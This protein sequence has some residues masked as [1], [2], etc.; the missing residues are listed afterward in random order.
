MFSAAPGL[1]IILASASP[2]RRELLAGLGL[3]FS[4]EPAGCAEPAPEAGEAA[5]S[6]AA[7]AALA[8]CQDCAKRIGNNR[9]AHSLIIAA[10][11]V[12]CLDG[13]IMG[14]PQSHE[15]AFAM[16]MR[17]SGREH[18]VT[19]AVSLVWT[20]F[21]GE[22]GEENFCESTR[23]FFHD[24]QDKALRAYAWQDEPM[25]KAGAYALQGRGAFL[26]D[27][28]SGS[29]SNVIGLPVTRLAATLCRLG[30]IFP[31]ACKRQCDSVLLA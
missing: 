20:A 18:T 27:G 26:I 10:D 29:V 16:L 11:T 7:R 13:E 24:W 4:V 28:V 25:D 2:R 8:K 22:S 14:K 12:V 19:T 3:T 9:R 1:S 31:T 6:F 5:E 21:P 30:L 23:V 17:L 15:H